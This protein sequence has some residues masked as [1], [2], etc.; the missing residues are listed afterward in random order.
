MHIK[1]IKLTI[2]VVFL[3]RFRTEYGILPFF[4]M[5]AILP[6][7]A[8]QAIATSHPEMVLP[9]APHASISGMSAGQS[10]QQSSIRQSS[11]A[12]SQKQAPR[13]AKYIG[14]DEQTVRLSAK[15]K[16]ELSGWEQLQP[17]SF[18]TQI[19]AAGWEHLL[20]SNP[21]YGSDKAGFGER[22][23]AAAIRQDSQAI[24]S[25]GVFAAAF[26]E[27]PRYYRK[28]SGKFLGRIWYSASR[29]LVTRTDAGNATTNASQLVGYAGAAALTMTY[30]PAVSATWSNTTEGYA[31]SL[32]GAALGNEVHEFTPDLIKLVFHRH[33]S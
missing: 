19:L 31:V 6:L 2:E 28:G 26:R 29:V 25:D 4:L 11:V 14:P 15:E 33:H 17:Y 22:L 24:L 8:Q 30:Y 21:K 27:D 7:F 20:N 9:D 16:L 3:L 5:A 13:L 10:E 18:G 1:R 32:A 12:G 23:G